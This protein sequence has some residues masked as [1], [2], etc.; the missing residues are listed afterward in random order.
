MNDATE[1]TLYSS[2][3]SPLALLIKTRVL[4]RN[5]SSVAVW[6]ARRARSHPT[7]QAPGARSPGLFRRAPNGGGYCVVVT[8]SAERLAHMGEAVED[9]FLEELV[10]QASVEAFDEGVR[11]RLAGRNVMPADAV[12]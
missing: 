1:L 4:L 3:L 5:T 8:P 2:D 11:R 12:L 6:R 7:A 9:L 10:P